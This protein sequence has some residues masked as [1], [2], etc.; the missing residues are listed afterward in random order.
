MLSFNGFRTA[1]Q[2]QLIQTEQYH[3]DTADP[4]EPCTV[5]GK[6][7]A[8]GGKAESQQEKGKADAQYKEQRIHHH[9]FTRVMY[10]SIFVH[11]LGSPCQITDIQRNKRQ[12]TGREKA[13]KP[14]YKYGNYRNSGF[15]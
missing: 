1:E 13:E 2:P 15:N 3:D 5:A 9:L 4:R 10:V 7:T 8:H 6:E 14:L 11:R 12:H